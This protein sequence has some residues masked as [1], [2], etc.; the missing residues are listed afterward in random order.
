MWL[1]SKNAN[2]QSTQAAELF[3]RGSYC[4]V[5]CWF[6]FFADSVSIANYRLKDS[7]HY[8]LN[9]DTAELW[10]GVERFSP[11]DCGSVILLQIMTI[12]GSLFSIFLMFVVY[13]GSISWF[14]VQNT[15]AWY[16]DTPLWRMPKLMSCVVIEAQPLLPS[17]PP[18]LPSSSLCVFVFP[19]REQRWRGAI[20]TARIWARLSFIWRME[21]RWSKPSKKKK[22]YP[23]TVSARLQETL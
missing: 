6:F 12:W 16:I 11:A 1:F 21:R 22:L 9:M 2:L 4:V 7:W 23:H 8:N 10:Y 17:L 18:S 15:F 19:S 13:I 3:T 14:T 5:P 20:F